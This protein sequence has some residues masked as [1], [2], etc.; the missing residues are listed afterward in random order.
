VRDAATGAEFHLTVPVQPAP[1]TGCAPG[2][3]DA[4]LLERYT[5]YTCRGGAMRRFDVAHAPWQVRPLDWVRSETEL[6]E[7]SFPWFAAA[8]FVCAHATPGVSEVRLGFP[9]RC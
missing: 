9:H 4:F 2:S 1:L 5:A 3:L 7:R 6:L 8:E